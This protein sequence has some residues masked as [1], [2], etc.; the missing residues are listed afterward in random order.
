MTTL[1]VLDFIRTSIL[2]LALYLCIPESDFI[3]QVSRQSLSGTLHPLAVQEGA[4]M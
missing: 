1:F 2:I 3:E 4:E